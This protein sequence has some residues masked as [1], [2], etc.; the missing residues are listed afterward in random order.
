MGT[1]VRFPLALSRI[2][3]H[4]LQFMSKHKGTQHNAQIN[5]N[6]ERT[7]TN[8]QS[9]KHYWMDE[10]S[11]SRSRCSKNF[12]RSGP[13]RGDW[14]LFATIG[15]GNFPWGPNSP[16]SRRTFLALL[17]PDAV[18]PIYACID[19][20]ET[21]LSNGCFEKWVIIHKRLDIQILFPLR[22]YIVRRGSDSLVS[23]CYRTFSSCVQLLRNQSG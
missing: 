19:F 5:G 7:E 8:R 13:L 12:K 23:G 11:L 4:P 18:T 22:S 15:S 10:S 9:E 2:P 21:W 16:K 14:S 6:I 17:S 1:P 3:Q 20:D